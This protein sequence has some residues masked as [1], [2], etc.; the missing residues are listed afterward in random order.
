[1]NNMTRQEREEIILEDIKDKARGFCSAQIKVVIRTIPSTKYPKG[2]KYEG[3]L[4]DVQEGKL[5]LDDT[6][7]M[8]RIE[9]YLSEIASP[10]DIYQ[11]EDK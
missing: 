6:Y 7:V 4:F 3:F 10:S 11:K 9:I 1:M 2:A 5:L 8:K